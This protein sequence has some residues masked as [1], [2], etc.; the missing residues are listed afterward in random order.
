[1]VCWEVSHH[2]RSVTAIVSTVVYSPSDTLTED[3]LDGV[4]YDPV[5]IAPHPHSEEAIAEE[6]VSH[7]PTPAVRHLGCLARKRAPVH[8][9]C[10]LAFSDLTPNL[11][12]VFKQRS[13]TFLELAFGSWSPVFLWC[14]VRSTLQTIVHNALLDRQELSRGRLKELS[15]RSLVLQH[16]VVVL[17]ERLGDTVLEHVRSLQADLKHPIFVSEELGA[18]LQELSLGCLIVILRQLYLDVRNV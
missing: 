18:A 10:W 14:R 8:A 1:M 3:R 4:H 12:A 5:P 16:G 9:T 6:Q 15:R 17:T 11:D 2:H 13:D 7:P